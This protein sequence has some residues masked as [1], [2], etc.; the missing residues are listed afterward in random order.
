MLFANAETADCWG[1][2]KVT[3]RDYKAAFFS[4]KPKSSLPL[5][6]EYLPAEVRVFKQVH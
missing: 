4:G 6:E 3:N 5:Y 1:L 2:I